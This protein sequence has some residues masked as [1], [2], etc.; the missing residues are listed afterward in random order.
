MTSS[1][2]SAWRRQR[3]QICS[4]PI[5]CSCFATW[6]GPRQ[7]SNRRFLE[8]CASYLA[9]ALASGEYVG[10]V[11][12]LTAPPHTAIGGAGVQFPDRSFPRT[13]PSGQRLLV[14]GKV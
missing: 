5:V 8:S 11:A 12:E 2:P 6:A 10:W 7:R 3:I 13:D 9:T 4:Q 1:L 14:G